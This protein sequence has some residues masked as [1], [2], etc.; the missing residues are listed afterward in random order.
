MIKFTAIAQTFQ[1]ENVHTCEVSQEKFII[2]WSEAVKICQNT[3]HCLAE[4]CC[5]FLDFQVISYLNEHLHIWCLTVSV[6]KYTSLLF[7]F[8]MKTSKWQIYLAE[9]CLQAAACNIVVKTQCHTNTLYT[10]PRDIQV[11]AG[12]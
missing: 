3:F 2:N 1:V 7:I 11:F 5:T 8:G 12:V 9:L 10:K 4:H 6:E